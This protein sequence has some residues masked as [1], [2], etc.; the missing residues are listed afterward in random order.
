MP[1]RVDNAFDGGFTA[2]TKA[3]KSKALKKG[4]EMVKLQKKLNWFF[5]RL[6]VRIKKRL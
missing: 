6:K 3:V 2:V 4:L 5:F 1:S